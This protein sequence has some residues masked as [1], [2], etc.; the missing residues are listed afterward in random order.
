MYSDD[1]FSKIAETYKA[2]ADPTRLKVLYSLKGGPKSV[3]ELMEILKIKQ[4]NL[5][6]HLSI[7]RNSGILKAKREK[8]NVYYSLTDNKITS[9]CDMICNYIKDKLKKEEKVLGMR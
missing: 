7:L 5:S 3:S 8:N 9:I 1:F 6:K 2:L 4:A